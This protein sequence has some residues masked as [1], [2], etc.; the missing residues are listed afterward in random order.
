LAATIEV[1][2]DTL[3]NFA[4]N[5]GDPLGKFGRDE[6]IAWESLMVEAL[7]LFELA[8][9]ESFE[10]AEDGLDGDCSWGERGRSGF[11]R[12]RVSFIVNAGLTG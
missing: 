12:D 7:E 2:T 8:G 9:F 11:G 3:A 1:N 6:I 5:G 10:A 4:T